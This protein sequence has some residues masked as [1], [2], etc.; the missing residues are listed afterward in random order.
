M[1]CSKR[2]GTE[3]AAETAGKSVCRDDAETCVFLNPGSAESGSTIER[4]SQAAFGARQGRC[5]TAS[6][7]ARRPPRDEPWKDA[8]DFDGAILHEKVP[9]QT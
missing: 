3:P 6:T 5:G 1:A 7:T 2:L 9:Q 4:S 8:V